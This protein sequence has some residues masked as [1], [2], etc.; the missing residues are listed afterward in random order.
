MMMNPAFLEAESAVF[1]VYAPL[2]GGSMPRMKPQ[3]QARTGYAARKLYRAKRNANTSVALEAKAL[4][5]TWPLRRSP[6][7]R[8]S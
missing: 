8:R 2:Q 3:E 5:A 6:R 4:G 1:R 7:G